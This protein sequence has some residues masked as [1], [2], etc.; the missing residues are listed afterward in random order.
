MKRRMYSA[1]I[2][3]TPCS[4]A[5]TTQLKLILSL[6]RF[7]PSVPFEPAASSVWHFPQNPMK[8]GLPAAA[9]PGVELLPDDPSATGTATTT[10]ATAAHATSHQVTRPLIRPTQS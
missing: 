3:P 10:A 6:S 5:L 8:S 7:G 4:T 9:L 1:W 2:P